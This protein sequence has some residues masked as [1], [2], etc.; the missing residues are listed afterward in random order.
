MFQCETENNQFFTP[1]FTVTK[2]GRRKTRHASST[3]EPDSSQWLACNV[4]PQCSGMHCQQAKVHTAQLSRRGANARTQLTDSSSNVSAALWRPGQAR[5][6]RFSPPANFQVNLI[7]FICSEF[8]RPGGLARTDMCFLYLRTAL[9]LPHRESR[10]FWASGLTPASSL[11]G[12]L[13]WVLKTRRSFTPSS[14]Y[15]FQPF[16]PQQAPLLMHVDAPTHGVA[17]PHPHQKS[18]LGWAWLGGDLRVEPVA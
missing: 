14:P 12:S 17:M 7:S 10:W 2:G 18:A 6:P 11:D 5:R 16:K 13:A 1:N 3:K 8:T 9:D 4:D 15:F